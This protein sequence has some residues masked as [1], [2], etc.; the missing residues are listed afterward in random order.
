MKKAI[1]VIFI[2]IIFTG[3]L[4]AQN[5]YE[6]SSRHKGPYEQK[7]NHK[8]C[9]SDQPYYQYMV[10][11]MTEVLELTP[12]QAEKLF[13]LNRPYRDKKHALHMEMNTISDEVFEKKEIT[14]ADLDKYKKDIER[15]HNEEAAL[16]KA[17]IEDVEK[18]L[19][20]AQVAKLIFFEPRFRRELSNELK[21]R[22]MPRKEE[23]KGKPF[24]QKRK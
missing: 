16:D 2:T 5:M 24:W 12:E 9:I 8:E 22:Y 13:P 7:P 6:G 11:R 17:F 3:S 23:K 1:T 21:D 15:L 4:L 19:A 18:F 20:P 14:K 10:F